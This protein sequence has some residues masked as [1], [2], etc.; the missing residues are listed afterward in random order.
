M[1][2]QLGDFLETRVNDFLKQHASQHNHHNH[3]NSH[4]SMLEAKNN[5]AG[6]VT[7][8]IL[9]CVDKTCEAKPHMKSRFDGECNE[10]YPFKT[11]AIFAFEEIDGT[12]VVFFGM[13]VQEYGS[14][15]AA[16][17]TRRVYI[18]YLD[19]VF[20]FR[21]KE[22]RTAVYHEIL[23]GYL[24]YVKRQGFQWAHIWAC[25][26][27]EGDDYIFH[28]HPVE[29]KVPKPKRLQDWY[30]KMLDKGVIE[31]VVIDYKDIHKDAIE[32]GMK[33][34]L[35]IPYFEGDFWPNVL[36]ECI[37]ESEQEEEK[38][39]KEEA[40]A[41]AAASADIANG[42]LSNGGGLGG[43]SSGGAGNGGVNSN[44]NGNKNNKKDS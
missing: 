5:Q 1:R 9:S 13:H 23:I 25:P 43:G 26:P 3:H 20:S 18:S 21:P 27:S 11:K 35:D 36:E 6:R 30:K 33:T 41:Q 22:L 4:Q 31:R 40:E 37:K 39:R 44:G 10:T 42:S 2:T 38:R 12:D 17:N 24:D 16:P 32:N 15:C 14:E 29:Q 7:I 8:R 28:C 34:P 19:S